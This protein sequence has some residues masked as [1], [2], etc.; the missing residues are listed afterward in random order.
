MDREARP[1]L[2]LLARRAHRQIV[3]WYLQLRY[4]GAAEIRHPN[5][6]T[7]KGRVSRLPSNRE[8]TEGSASARLQ[9]CYGATLKIGYPDI[10][11]VIDHT[12]RTISR[13][14]GAEDCPRKRQLGDIVAAE[15]AHPDVSSIKRD[16][17]RVGSHREGAEDC[18]IACP[19]FGHIAAAV[20]GYPDARAVESHGIRGG[21][22]AELCGQVR[23]VP[24]QNRDL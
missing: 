4:R 8:S 10:G 23:V 12:I 17:S 2:S 24:V 20:V 19:Q 18:A 16:A 3:S 1:A 14:K 21:S 9:L 7:V 15:I 13:G 5:T 6:G 11:A 22:C